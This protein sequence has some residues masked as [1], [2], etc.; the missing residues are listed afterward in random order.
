MKTWK[1]TFNIILFLFAFNTIPYCQPMIEKIIPA[2]WPITNYISVQKNKLPSFSQK[3]GGEI[4]S[5]ENYI[6][7]V[8]GIPLQINVVECSNDSEAQNVYHTL[9]T[10][11]KTDENYL[12]IHHTVYEFI[13]QN[14]FIMKKAKSL[15]HPS[16]D[17]II[18]N[19]EL[20]IAPLT[21]SD[22]MEF[23]NLFNLLCAYNNDKNNAEIEEKILQQ[24]KSFTFTDIITFNNKTI[25]SIKPKYQINADTLESSKNDVVVFKVNDPP[26]EL[27]IPK[28]HVV[29]SI[30]VQGFTNYKPQYD[31]DVDFYTTPNM[32]WPSDN[33]EILSLLKEI[34]KETDTEVQK[35]ETIQEWVYS[36]IRYDGIMGSRYGTLQVLHQKY[37]RC[38]DKCDMFVTL[39]KAAHLPAR[40]IGGWV[41]GMG[42][43]VWAEV[44]IQHEGWVSVDATAPFLGVSDDYVPFFII[45]T[46]KIPAVYWDV[47]VLKKGK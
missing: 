24:S 15:F 26:Q 7:A 16:E 35:L 25:H 12:L 10:L 6:L 40:Q 31:I 4:V 38:W 11:Q 1:Y 17:T 43:H 42:G 14:S 32:Y 18:W 20:D 9:A 34:L 27:T 13:S 21:N 45:E 5:V 30:P 8:G 44:Y 33:P 46:G 37:G 22:D 47:P 23:N 36:N 28:I 19:V 39:C 3:L 41:Q 29:A 2:N